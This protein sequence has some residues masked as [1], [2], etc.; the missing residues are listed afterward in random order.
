[1]FGVVLTLGVVL[2]AAQTEI[3]IWLL[4][5]LRILLFSSQLLIRSLVSGCALVYG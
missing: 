1:V 3:S 4:L 2:A 5:G